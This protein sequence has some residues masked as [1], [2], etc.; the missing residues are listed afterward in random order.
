VPVREAGSDQRRRSAGR[1]DRYSAPTTSISR[2]G[3]AGSRCPS[4]W[5]ALKWVANQARVAAQDVCLRANDFITSRSVCRRLGFEDGDRSGLIQAFV[6]PPRCFVQIKKRRMRL[7]C[8]RHATAPRHL[9]CIA[10]MKTC[11]LTRCQFVPPALLNLETRP[12]G[13]GGDG[14]DLCIGREATNCLLRAGNMA[15]DTDLKD[16]P[17]RAQQGHL[18]IWLDLADE[19]RRRTG[20]RFIVSLAAVF[21]FDAHRLS[22]FACFAILAQG[23]SPVFRDAARP[24]ET[25][26]TGGCIHRRPPVSPVTEG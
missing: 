12:T 22:S 24:R 5:Q 9:S 3:I 17:A 4:S 13:S 23:L 2:Y 21:D 10:S 1:H 19:V 6:P 15:V 18:R 16:T 25:T 26:A 20:A 8:S 11:A 14:D 7:P